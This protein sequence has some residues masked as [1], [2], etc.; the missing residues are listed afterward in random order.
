[1]FPF[2]ISYKI[3]EKED[4]VWQLAL[5]LKKICEYVFAPTISEEMA[6]QLKQMIL[7]YLEQ[8]AKL[9]QKPL[10]PKHHYLRHYPDLIVIFGP[11]I[12][13][14]TMRFESRHVFFKQAAKAANNFKNITKTLVNKY[15]LN[16][17]FKFTGLMVPSPI[18]FK[19][20][21]ASGL[22][23]DLNPEVE[24]I[25]RNN[26]SFRSILKRVEVHGITYEPGM[27]LLLQKRGQNFQY[28]EIVLILFNGFQVKYIVKEHEAEDSLEGYYRIL[29]EEGFSSVLQDDLV[30]YY[31][32]SSYLHEGY[33]C[34]SIKHASLL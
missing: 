32:L 31:P 4:P 12:R 14:W 34:L 22:P 21:D 15:V 26:V 10:Q 27:W 16:F 2:L 1:M 6:V 17:A 25:L 18:T 8:R 28:G 24:N 23:E 20:K 5:L 33:Q 30:D 19:D 3:Q 9:F 29:D 13:L 11:L 7:I